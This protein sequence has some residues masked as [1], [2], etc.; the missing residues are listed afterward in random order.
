MFLAMDI[1]KS[2]VSASAAKR[3]LLLPKQQIKEQRMSVYIPQ[4]KLQ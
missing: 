1:S 2:K 3:V 4:L